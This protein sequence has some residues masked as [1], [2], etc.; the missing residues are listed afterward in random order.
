MP[1]I[2]MEFRLHLRMAGRQ[3]DDLA[4]IF[5]PYR[6]TVLARFDC[7]TDEGFCERQGVDRTPTLKLY[8]NGTKASSDHTARETYKADFYHVDLM[9]PFLLKMRAKYLGATDGSAPDTPPHAQPSTAAAAAA[10]GAASAATQGGAIPATQV[11][12]GEYDKP[13]DLSAAAH[14]QSAAGQSAEQQGGGGECGFTGA[15]GGSRECGAA[16]DG[17]AE[18]GEPRCGRGATVQATSGGA[19]A[20]TGGVSQGSEGEA[21]GPRRGR[22]GGP[23]LET[24]QQERDEL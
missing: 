19:A 24:L 21:L 7:M 1:F 10:A 18:N 5:L 2:L 22:H 16:M 3:W 6:D 8:F 23:A 9:R 12:P 14:Q 20:A 17:R 15:E 11:R 4:Q 13:A